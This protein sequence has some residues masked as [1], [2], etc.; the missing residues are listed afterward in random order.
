MLSQNVNNYI[1]KHSFCSEYL[2]K[3]GNRFW[4]FSMRKVVAFQLYP[5]GIIAKSQNSVF[6]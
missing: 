4:I 6:Q 3:D 1:D 2:F 5:G